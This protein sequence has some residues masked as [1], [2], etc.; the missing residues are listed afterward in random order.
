VFN[1]IKKIFFIFPFFFISLLPSSC[2][3]DEAPDVGYNYFPDRVGKYVVYEVDSISKDDLLN[4]NDTFK[5]QLKEVIQS[6]YTDNQGRPTMR[7]E[8]YK[9]FYNPNLSYDSMQWTLTDVW[10]ATRT[11]T[12]LETNEENITYTRMIFPVRKKDLTWD[13]N[14]P[15]IFEAWDYEYALVDLPETI[16]NIPFDSVATIEEINSN[17]LVETKYSEAKY[18]KNVGL[19]YRKLVLLGKQ[20]AFV[21]EQ[22][23]Y[24]DTIALTGYLL[25]SSKAIIYT[26]KVIAYGN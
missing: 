8:R 14:A 1:R 5:M 22:P 3:K 4:V 19:V 23:P 10:S 2:K 12:T 16:N 24:S 7:M 20:P 6:I 17:N 13:G 18:A 26:Q 11:N 21:G 15:N 25:Y 9:K